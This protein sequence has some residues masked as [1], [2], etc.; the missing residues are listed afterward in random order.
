MVISPLLGNVCFS[1]SQY[2]FSF[3][4]ESFA[5]LYSDMFGKEGVGGAVV[6]GVAIVNFVHHRWR[7]F[8]SRIFQAIMGRYLF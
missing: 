8:T 4:L 3:T 1:S 7:F 6:R 5:K 2:G